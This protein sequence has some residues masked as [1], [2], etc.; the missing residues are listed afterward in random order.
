MFFRR[1]DMVWVHLENQQSYRSF[2]VKKNPVG[3]AQNN[4]F[5]PSISHMIGGQ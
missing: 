2:E 3:V 4:I 5:I 1:P